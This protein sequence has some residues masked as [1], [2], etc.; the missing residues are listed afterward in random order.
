MGKYYCVGDIG[1]QYTYP[2]L[3]NLKSCCLFQIQKVDLC[4]GSC[5]LRL[6][7]AGTYPQLLAEN[8]GTKKGA[9]ALMIE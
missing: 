1:V 6:Y 8:S 9:V 5:L 2:F 7:P 3:L 4:L